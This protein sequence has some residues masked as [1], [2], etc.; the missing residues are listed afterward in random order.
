MNFGNGLLIIKASFGED[1]RR[2]HTFGSPTYPELIQTMKH[3][4]Q[5]QLDVNCDLKLKY[6]LVYFRQNLHLNHDRCMY[7]FIESCHVNI[8]NAIELTKDFNKNFGSN[9]L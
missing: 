1:I 2:I 5:D 8:L 7:F 3:L 4:F 6:R 9:H